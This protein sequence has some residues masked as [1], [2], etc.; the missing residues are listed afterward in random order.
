[1]VQWRD[2]CHQGSRIGFR[3]TIPRWATLSSNEERQRWNSLLGRW[4]ILFPTGVNL[5]KIS[6]DAG[7]FI[8]CDEP[9]ESNQ[10][11]GWVLLKKTAVLQSRSQKTF[12]NCT[13][14]LSTNKPAFPMM[15]CISPLRAANETFFNSWAVNLGLQ[16]RLYL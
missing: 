13:I 14:H 9:A 6:N 15:Q 5:S 3:C 16:I 1:M 8:K 10:Q 4:A 7:T 2:N 12:I 11:W